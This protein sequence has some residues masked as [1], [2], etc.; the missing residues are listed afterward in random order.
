MDKDYLGLYI[1]LIMVL[2]QTIAWYFNIDGA[3]T[4]LISLIIGGISGSLFGFNIAKIKENK[5]IKKKIEDLRKKI[6]ENF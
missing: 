4:G 1:I 6:E 3:T 5:D 2:F